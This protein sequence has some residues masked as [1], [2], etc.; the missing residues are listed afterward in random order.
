MIVITE[1]LTEKVWT[2]RN[3]RNASPPGQM[4]LQR[5]DFHNIF[6]QRLVSR[7]VFCLAFR[8][9][10]PDVSGKDISAH[11]T[12]SYVSISIIRKLESR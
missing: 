7:L 10:D 5:S 8:Q 12:G 3:F 1:K 2:R 4:V 6:V 9:T 11:I